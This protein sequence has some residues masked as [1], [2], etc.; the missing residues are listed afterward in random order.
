MIGIYKIQSLSGKIYIGQ[1]WNIR[2][3]KSQYSRAA[4]KKQ[5]KLYSSIKKYG[6][7]NHIFE[8]IHELPFDVKQEILNEYE[9]LYWELYNNIFEMMNIVKP[10]NSRKQS[11]ETKKKISE[12]AKGRVFTEE[13]LKN[14]SSSHIGIKNNIGRKFTKEHKEKIG[15]TKIGN[16]YN[17]GRKMTEYNKIK[18]AEGRAKRDNTIN[19]D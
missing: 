3:R 4:C 19:N 11:E 9:L 6:W 1:S 2:K 5:L 10:G 14:L 17:L 16:K 8:I 12:K 15:K 13:H 18:L 7:E